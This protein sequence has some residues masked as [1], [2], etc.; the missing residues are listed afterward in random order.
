ME[1]QLKAVGTYNNIENSIN[2]INGSSH[3]FRG[4]LLTQLTVEERHFAI[5]K[6]AKFKKLVGSNEEIIVPGFVRETEEK[7]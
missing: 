4:L 7:K 2:F 1:Q 5:Q 6:W 3:A